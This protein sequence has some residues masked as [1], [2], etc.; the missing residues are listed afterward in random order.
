[1]ATKETKR[2]ADAERLLHDL[3]GI[4]EAVEEQQLRRHGP[5]RGELGYAVPISLHDFMAGLRRQINGYFMDGLL[6]T[7]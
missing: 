7:D 6:R 5:E 3:V 2:L 1:M 4:L